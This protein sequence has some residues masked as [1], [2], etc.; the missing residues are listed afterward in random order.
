MRACHWD[1]AGD[2]GVAT[3]VSDK[4]SLPMCD[5]HH[6][7]HRGDRE[8]VP[9]LVVLDQAHQLLELLEVE[10]RYALLGGEC[11][12]RG[13]R[14]PPIGRSVDGLCP[15]AGHMGKSVAFCWSWC[16]F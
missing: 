6:R 5:E 11:R 7:I 13:H 16:T 14:W 3:K 8:R 2:K 1:E 12:V 9:D 10:L 4:F 15:A